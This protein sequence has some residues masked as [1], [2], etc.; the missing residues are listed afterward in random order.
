MTRANWEYRTACI[1]YDG[2]K[3]KDWVVKGQEEAGLVGFSAILEAYGSRGWE[4][5]SLNLERTRAFPGFGAWHV[6]PQSY[7]AT[8][9][10][11]AEASA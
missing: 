10:R 8:F 5:I 2:R 3:Q 6:E 4:L 7:R 1:S 9:G 11:S